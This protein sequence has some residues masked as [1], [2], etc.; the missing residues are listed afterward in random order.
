MI[1]KDRGDCCYSKSE[2]LLSEEDFYPYQDDR[3]YT[4][5]YSSASYFKEYMEYCAECF[6]DMFS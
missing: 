2:Y 5:R 4:D 6:D 3:V 1:E